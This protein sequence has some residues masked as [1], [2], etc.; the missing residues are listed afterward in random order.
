[1]IS[2]IT[3]CPIGIIRMSPDVMGLVQTSNNVARVRVIGKEAEILCLT[4]S[5]SESEKID[6]ANRIAGNMKMAGFETSF[7]GNYPGWEPAHLLDI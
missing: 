5:S 3:G 4:R 7:S 1:L 2:A 6:C